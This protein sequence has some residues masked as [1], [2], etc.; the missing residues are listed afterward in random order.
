LTVLAAGSHLRLVQ[1]GRW[2]FA[3]RI[4]A[5][6]VVYILAITDDRRIIFVEQERVPVG[7]SVIELP[8]GLV[9]D[10][11]GAGEDYAEAARRELLEETGYTAEQIERLTEGPPSAGMSSEIVTLC[12]AT[13][14][15]K[16]GEG[17]GVGHEKIIVH[18]IPL[19]EVHN[20]LAGRPMVD[21]KVYAG[22]YFAT[23]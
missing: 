19:A 1:R 20:W 16:T 2:E 11:G 21:P 15:T 14:L 3:D 13:G 12:R 10:E 4:G 8:A 6:G 22:L 5:S 7:G 9:G 23:R 17:G 18:E